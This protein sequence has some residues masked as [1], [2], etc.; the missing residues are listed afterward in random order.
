M[1][2]PKHTTNLDFDYTI[3][4]NWEN[5][6]Q[7]EHD[8]WTALYDRQSELL[9]ERAC[10]QFLEGLKKLNLNNG[11]IPNFRELNEELRALTGWE[12][13]AVPDL[14]PDGAFFK[15]LAARQF[16][17]GCFMRKPEQMDYLSEPDVFHDVFGHVPMLS[18]PVYANYMEAYGEGGMRSLE[19]DSLHHVARL[20]W[21]TVEFGLMHSPKGLR[22]Y[23][24][25]ILSSKSESIFCLES[26]SPHRIEFDLVRVM[27]TD[28]RIDDFQQT[29]FVIKDFDQ[30][31]SETCQ[32]LS[33]IYERL[34][35][36]PTIQPTD[37]VEGPL[38]VSSGNQSHALAAA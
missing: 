11:G 20:Y 21:Y 7:T 12:V 14:V 2:S 4:Q 34:K 29:Y 9:P 35:S 36:A 8:T 30:L 18:H 22:I 6:T 16:P 33:S 28:Y 10:P 13:V 26:D 27:Q 23:G 5:Y 17:A 32:D 31:L 24:A 3:E 38:V 19:F 37:P 25:G 1:G 15:M